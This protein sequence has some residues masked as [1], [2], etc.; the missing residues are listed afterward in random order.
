MTTPVVFEDKAEMR[1]WSREARRQGKSIGFVPTM[2]NGSL[3]EG[4]LALV[5]AASERCDVV[6]VSIYVNPTQF[7]RDEDFDKY[8]CS[9][10]DDLRK[11][12]TVGAAAIFL[13][14][15]LYHAPAGG[16]APTGGG[17]D[18]DAA[19]V[20]GATAAGAADPDAHETWVAVE[21]LSQGLCGRSRP[22]F[23]RGVCTVVAK[24]FHICEPDVAF[25]GKKD[26][27]QWRVLERMARD[28]DF[29]LQVVGLPIVREADGLAM[30]SRNKLLSP[31][32]RAAAVCI[33]RAL[34]AA[35]DAC[36]AGA[37]GGAPSA[38][39]LR[40]RVAGAIE[41]GGGRIDY[42]EVVDA[43]S[44]QPAVDPCARP[45]LVAVAVFF[46]SVRLIDNIE[47]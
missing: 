21:R 17:G 22:H 37:G 3:H 8:P 44:L 13:P 34:A 18:G 2:V 11:L 32:D 30:S 29:G 1:A 10:A 26:Y 41:A 24:L 40:A 45:T 36:G 42:V 31:A 4:H 23:F 25:F 14:R 33:S 39:E 35:R 28:L 16:G 5:A 43:R 20:V 12:E 15:S 38:E 6:V 27:Q 46:G 9:W 7:S 19:L 47:L